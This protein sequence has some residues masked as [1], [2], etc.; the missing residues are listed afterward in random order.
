[1]ASLGVSPEVRP[2][3]RFGQF[4]STIEAGGE[5]ALEEI[6]A[7]M[8][9]NLKATTPKVTGVLR[10]GTNAHRSGNKIVGKTDA[11]IKYAPGVEGGNPPHV[12]RRRPTNA[13]GPGPLAN[14]PGSNTPNDPG[15]FAPSGKV[16]HPGN[17][18]NPYLKNAYDRTWPHAMDIV[19]ANID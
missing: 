10:A 14:N 13:D 9:D 16:N 12:I 2:R 19:D 15:F 18:P 11:E 1:M 6:E 3:S 5:A 7:L 8:Q 4:I 17:K